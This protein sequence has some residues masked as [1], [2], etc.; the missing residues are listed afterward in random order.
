MR[1]RGVKKLNLWSKQIKLSTII[2]SCVGCKGVSFFSCYSKE[3]KN[4][5]HCTCN[6]LYN[7]KIKKK[8]KVIEL[9]TLAVHNF[10]IMDFPILQ[11]VFLFLCLSFYF[12]TILYLLDIVASFFQGYIFFIFWAFSSITQG[13]LFLKSV[14][15]YDT[16]IF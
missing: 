10:E 9:I 5:I 13:I 12:Q 4:D 7:I 11:I 1:S 14:T 16:C 8:G 3:S 2:V 15:L 6:P